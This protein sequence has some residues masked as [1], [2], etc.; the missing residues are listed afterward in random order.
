MHCNCI[1]RHW[2]ARI[3]QQ[4]PALLVDEPVAIGAEH[5]VLPSDF[6]YVIRSIA[7]GFKIDDA[8]SGNGMSMMLS[9][10]LPA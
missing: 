4:R 9:G 6:A 10:S 2:T 8:N 5:D 1:E 3:K 7:A